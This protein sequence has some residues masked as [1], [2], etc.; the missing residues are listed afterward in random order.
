MTFVVPMD[1]LIVLAS[2]GYFQSAIYDH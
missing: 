2:L 1:R